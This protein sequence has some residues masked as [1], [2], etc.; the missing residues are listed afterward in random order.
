MLDGENMREYIL[1][2]AR[3]TVERIVSNHIGDDMYPEQ[4]DMDQLNED[5]LQ[6]VPIEPIKLDE[7]LSKHGKKQDIIELAQQAAIALYEEKEKT[8]FPDIEQFREA[9]RVVLLNVIDRH[10]MNHIDDMD[11][12]RQGIG[13]QSYG[14]RDPVQEYKFQGYEMFENMI[15]SISE[16]TIRLLMNLRVEQK[17]ERKEVAKITGTNKDDTVANAPIRRATKKV[18]P[19][20][21]CPCGSGKKYKFCCMKK[22]GAE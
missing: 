12:L 15:N 5:L 20:D 6:I 1:K 4:W 9:E 2:M 8:L 17:V 14:Q 16:D 13:L 21:P 3:N 10:W 22:G 18:Q 19:N 7:Y 11:Q